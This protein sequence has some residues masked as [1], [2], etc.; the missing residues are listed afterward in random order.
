MGRRAVLDW[1]PVLSE[2]PKPR[3]YASLIGKFI[4]VVSIWGFNESA[5]ARNIFSSEIKAMS[6]TDRI[7]VDNITDNIQGLSRSDFGGNC[8]AETP[9]TAFSWSQRRYFT[10]EAVRGIKVES[11]ETILPRV[12]PLRIVH[13]KGAAP[14]NSLNIVSD[15]RGFVRAVVNDTRRPFDF[16]TPDNVRQFIFGVERA[17]VTFGPDMQTRQ[18]QFRGISADKLFIRNRQLSLSSSIS[19]VSAIGGEQSATRG[20]EAYGKSPPGKKRE[21]RQYLLS[22]HS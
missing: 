4:L 11:F 15:N 6:G 19:S 21:T 5:F 22:C 9:S 8:V 10:L 7:Q 3:C 13:R 14:P 1:F 16:G 20:S 12:S 2:E 17:S 18:I